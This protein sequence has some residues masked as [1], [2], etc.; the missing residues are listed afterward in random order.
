[1]YPATHQE[2]DTL[3]LRVFGAPPDPASAKFQHDAAAIWA[4][5]LKIDRRDRDADRD[6]AYRASKQLQA[7]C[8]QCGEASTMEGRTQTM[9]HPAE[10]ISKAVRER[11]EYGGVGSR[12]EWFAALLGVVAIYRAAP[13][14]N[15]P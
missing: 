15:N 3:L 5:V 9:L 2:F 6:T 1:M 12:G 8:L 11:I 10:D 14:I 13:H 4:E 7:L